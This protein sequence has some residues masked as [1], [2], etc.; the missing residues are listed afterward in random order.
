M[1]VACIPAFNEERT[2]QTLIMKCKKYVNIVL[3]CDDGSTDSTSIVAKRAGAKVIMHQKNLGKGAAL[4][5]LF[6]A[7]INQNADI[8]ITLDADGSHDPDDIPILLE[9]ILRGTFKVDVVIGSRFL[10]GDYAHVSRLNVL[11]NKL[12]NIL[13][14]FFN[15]RLLSDS[16]SGFRVFKR[17]ILNGLDL[18]AKGYQVETEFTIKCIRKHHC[19]ILE[20]PIQ[21]KRSYRVSG[22]NSFR[23]GFKIIRIIPKTV[24]REVVLKKRGKLAIVTYLLGNPGAPFIINFIV[25]LVVCVGLILNE[26]SAHANEIG[27]YAYFS[28]IIGSILQL[29]GSLKTKN[30]SK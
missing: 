10:N 1:I 14:F 19:R 15:G 12:I 3:V 29:V 23:D 11:G 25:L 16:Q 27:M 2:L 26:N 24:L 5:T 17:W 7:A 30:A 22:L 28:L 6:K 13:I 8:L 9:P 4:T 18:S 21:S 20:I